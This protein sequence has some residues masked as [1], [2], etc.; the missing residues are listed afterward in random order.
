MSTPTLRSAARDGSKTMNR[1][2][3][4]VGGRFNSYRKPRSR[5]R[6]DFHLYASAMKRSSAVCA[7]LLAVPGRVIANELAL[8]RLNAAIL[9]KLNRPTSVMKKLLKKR[10][11]SPPALIEC[12]PLNR[13][14]V[15]DTTKLVSPRP[16]GT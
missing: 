14:K 9:G 2:N 12:D 1:L 11:Y 10:R 5:V 15:S 3:L 4:S 7:I 13:L 16:W 6:F 8:P